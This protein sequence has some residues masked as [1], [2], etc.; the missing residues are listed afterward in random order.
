VVAGINAQLGTTP[1][2]SSGTLTLSGKKIDVTRYAVGTAFWWL[3]V[4]ARP[5]AVLT[6]ACQAR[7]PADHAQAS[8]AKL[9]ERLLVSE[10]PNRADLKNGPLPIIARK[11]LGVP[12][13]C[14]Y[15]GASQISCPEGN[16]RWETVR[17][18]LPL[19]KVIGTFFENVKAEPG[20]RTDMACAV[21]GVKGQ[22][23]EAFTLG[24]GP[25]PRLY[26]LFG[27]WASEGQHLYLICNAFTPLTPKL[28]GVCAQVFSL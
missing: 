12:K 15:D 28:P 1:Q 4:V 6:L 8:C 26:M 23:Y 21:G 14:S 3:T 2:T 9:L 7:G 5:R 18:Q 27:E 16:L 13:G 24:P 17:T 10:P 20:S 22:C 11:P 25:R 19:A